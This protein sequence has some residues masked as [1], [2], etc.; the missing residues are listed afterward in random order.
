MMPNPKRIC[1]VLA[2]FLLVCGFAADAQKDAAQP[3]RRIVFGSCADQNQPQ[4]IWEAILAVKPGL[5]LSIGDAVY[6]NQGTE[7]RAARL[8]AYARLGAVPGFARLRRAA[9]MLAVW[10]DG[11]F[12]VNDGGADF[13]ARDEFRADFLDFFGEPKDSPRRTRAGMYDAQLYGPAGKRVQIILL[14]TRYNRS[15]LKRGNFA[16]DTGRYVPDT[17]PAK[18]MLGEEQWK[19]LEEQLR[20]PAEIRFLVSSIQVIPEDHGWEKWANLPL[21][22]QRLFHLIRLTGARGVLFLSGDRH[23]AELSM[24]DGGVGY[25][26]YD[27]TS[28]GL[29]VARHNWRPYEANRHR[30]GTLNWGDNFGVIEMDWERADPRIS[31]QIRDAD[32]EIAIQR[33]IPLSLLQPGVVRTPAQP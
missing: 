25:P 20:V 11:E 10:D 28:S 9:P 32:G 22:R 33:K 5:Y 31:L 1:V 18:T 30:V 2:A 8:A 6:V 24:M 3:L 29:N 12:G 17:D 4:P 15:P 7:D 21:E 14:D 26:L 13:T 16:P 27:L 19:W 23:L